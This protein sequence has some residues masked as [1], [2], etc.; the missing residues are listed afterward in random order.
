MRLYVFRLMMIYFINFTA[1]KA[2]AE[3]EE[4]GTP[5][6]KSAHVV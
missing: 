4:K 2:E 6:Q 5:V 1:T 3:K